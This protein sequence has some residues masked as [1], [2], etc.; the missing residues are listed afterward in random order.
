MQKRSYRRVYKI[1]N[2][3]NNSGNVQIF[4]V[5]LKGKENVIFPSSNIEIYDEETIF[6]FELSSDVPSNFDYQ[7]NRWRNKEFEST[8]IN[9][10]AKLL[11]N[12]NIIDN[13][14]LF[15]DCQYYAFPV[16]YN[17]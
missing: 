10:G 13:L 8:L 6:M 17:V 2:Y 3:G 7:Y 15:I 4:N 5:I 12:N 1:R 14:I 9:E 16:P 11:C